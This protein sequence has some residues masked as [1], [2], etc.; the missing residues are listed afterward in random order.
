MSNNGDNR[1]LENAMTPK[2]KETVKN[3]LARRDCEIQLSWA[4]RETHTA[5]KDATNWKDRKPSARRA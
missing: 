2:V 5:S 1:Q 3:F 4:A